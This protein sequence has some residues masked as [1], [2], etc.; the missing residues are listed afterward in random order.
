M[1]RCRVG[2][3]NVAGKGNAFK[4]RLR[5]WLHVRAIDFVTAGKCRNT[6]C[7]RQK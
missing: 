4:Q 1:R 2:I 7:K 5:C 6:A 3:S